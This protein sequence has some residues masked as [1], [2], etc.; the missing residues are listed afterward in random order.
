[1]TT[2]AFLGLGAMGSRMAARLL[3][4][5]NTLKVWNRSAAA[6]DALAAQGASLAASPREAAQGADIVMSMLT[7]DNASRSVWLDAVSGAIHGLKAGAIAIES[8][9]VS[10]QWVRELHEASQMRNA[11]LLDAPVAG[12]R[13]QAEAGQLV[14]MVGG[15]ASAVQTVRPELSAMAATVHHVGTTGQGAVLKL[16]VNAL[17]AAQLASAA[18]L[19]GLLGNNGFTRVQAAELLCAFPVTSGPAAAALKL[20]ASQADTRLFTV[21]LLEKDLAYAQ[22]LAEASQTALPG[23]AR[24]RETFVQAQNRGWGSENFSSIARLFF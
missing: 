7:D 15:P 18:E 2:I 11:I 8:S 21:D 1:M 10:P 9:T 5:G 22:Q 3:G 24:T 16:A 13:P 14:F 20:M 6:A 19:L 12:S 23:V 17:F 4:A